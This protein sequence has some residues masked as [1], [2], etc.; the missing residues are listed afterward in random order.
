MAGLDWN[1]SF[2][3]IVTGQVLGRTPQEVNVQEGN[4]INL[5]AEL[6]AFPDNLPGFNAKWIRKF[7]KPP[8]TVNE[9]ENLVSDNDHQIVSEGLS[10]GHVNEEITI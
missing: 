3:L 2:A 5:S 9:T 7:I 4:S 10:G 6:A 8:K 1:P